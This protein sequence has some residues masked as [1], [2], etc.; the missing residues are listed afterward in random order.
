MQ[1][2]LLRLGLL[3][4]PKPRSSLGEVELRDYERWQD[5]GYFLLPKCMHRPWHRLISEEF[6][7]TTEYVDT[8]VT[9]TRA[10]DLKDHHLRAYQDRIVQ[11]LCSLWIWGRGDVI[12]ESPAF[13]RF[14]H[15]YEEHQDS[16]SCVEGDH[17]AG[18]TVYA[19][20]GHP[21]EA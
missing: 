17:V 19:V 13:Q 10:S 11:K 20:K 3:R 1:N 6:N 14:I 15:A 18:K 5:H 2:I 8:T 12:R 7:V 9:N 16:M 21:E 4:P